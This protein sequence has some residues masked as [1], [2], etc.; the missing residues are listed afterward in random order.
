MS[1]EYC[2]DV[3][4][5]AANGEDPTIDVEHVESVEHLPG[6]IDPD[7]S[8][9]RVGKRDGEATG[10]DSEF[11]HGAVMGQPEER[12]DRGG[13]VEGCSVPVV[14]HI[15]EG[16]TVGGGVERMWRRHRRSLPVS[17]RMTRRYPC[18]MASYL[19]HAATGPMRP[20]AIEAMMPFLSDRFANPSGAHRSARDARRALDDAREELADLVGARPGDIVFTSGG[21]ESDNLAIFGLGAGE[22]GPVTSAVE[23]HA[24]LDPVRALGGTV[25]GVDRSGAVDVDDLAR[26]L[27]SGSPRVV[28]LMVVNNE[29]GVISDLAALAAVV[30]SVAPSAVVHSDAVQG[31]CWT[32]IAD[33]CSSVDSFSLSAHKFGG[34][35]GVGALIVREGIPITA[36][37]LGGGQERERRSGTQNVAGIVA[38]TTAARL[39][40]RD[41]SGEI[42]RVAALRD[43]LLDGLLATIPDAVE[44]VGSDRSNRAAGIAHLCIPGVESEALLFLLERGEVSAS[45]ASSCA[46]G[47]VQSS[48]VLEAMGVDPSLA[49][50]SLRLSLGWSS[51]ATDVDEALAVIPPAVERLR[52]FGL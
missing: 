22:G 34:P 5:V 51:T 50:G 40:A 39:A 9:T 20:E 31:F 48:H 45:A 18:P 3:G 24:V 8:E 25:V 13:G 11:E 47:A 37:Q 27:Q 44:T 43:R 10:S 33:A 4:H 28:S 26:H 1:T 32:D 35:K 17:L 2:I 46:S 14:V 16:T 12:V 21:T 23:H 38:M 52:G 42:E 41:R 36:R 30:R 6:C 19:D 15:G 7:H 29:T 49:R